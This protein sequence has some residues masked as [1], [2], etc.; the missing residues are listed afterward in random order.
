MAAD[1]GFPDSVAANFVSVLEAAE[2]CIPCSQFFHTVESSAAAIGKYVSTNLTVFLKQ[3]LIQFC[4]VL[5][6]DI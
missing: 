6:S 2:G 3:D 1:S 5:K 4:S